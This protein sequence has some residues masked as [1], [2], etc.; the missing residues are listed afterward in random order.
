M[1]LGMN[2]LMPFPTKPGRKI[3]TILDAFIYT[4]P[5]Y[6]SVGDRMM[7]LRMQLQEQ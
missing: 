3:G 7:D 2:F 5:S 4:F 1:G 6:K